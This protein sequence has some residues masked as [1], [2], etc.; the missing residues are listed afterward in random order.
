MKNRLH[1]MCGKMAAGKSTLSTKIANEKNAIFLSEDE[2]L[3][4]LYPNEIKT[5]EDYIKYSKRLKDTMFEFVIQLLKKGN[6]VVLDF[7][8]N[9]VFQRE[10][11]K[12]IFETA[13]V[14]HIMYYVKRSDEV[15]KV[16]LKKRNEN[17]PK[18]TPLIDE[19]T[20]DAI[21]KYFQ[22]P[23]KNEGFN[24]KYE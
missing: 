11:F 2:L 9:T 17:L 5:I 13:N 15:C 7:P 10:W 3:K 24:I 1:F 8:A 4:K 23:K 20:F 16:Q 12:D 18:D 6:E 19:S 22:E 21:T 14:E